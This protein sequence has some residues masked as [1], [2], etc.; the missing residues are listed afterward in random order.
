MIEVGLPTTPAQIDSVANDTIK[1]IEKKHGK[2]TI[3]KLGDRPKFIIPV[4]PTGVY[5]IDYEVLGVGGFP[6]GRIIEVMGPES[7]GKTTLALRVIAAAQAAGGKA[8]FIDVEHA[9]DP[10][11]AE[12]N[13]V[14][15]DELYVSQP[16][17]GEEALEVVNDLVVSG[18]WKVIVVDSVA[19]LVPKAELEGEMGDS[20]MGLQARLMS[21][22]MRKL[23]GV[24]AKTGTC[25]IFIN[26][27]RDKIGV[28][29]GSPEVTTGGKALKF[30]ASVRIDIRRIGQV[31]E[32]DNVVG[33][34]IKVKAV[35]NK[36]AAPFK[37][38]ECVLLY[39]SGFDTDGS[40]FDAAVEAKVIDK[41]GSW[42]SYKTEKIG[43]GRDNALAYLVSKNLMD[44]ILK[45]VRDGQSGTAGTSGEPL[46]SST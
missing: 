5:G 18:A 33:N 36:V 4:T 40:V 26:Q 8:A 28:L 20:H 15:T 22:A 31:K 41:S 19:A 2:G 29:F 23:T 30:Y 12:R 10:S 14:I 35:K 13:G 16:D 45:E 38:T 25:L 1:A 9:L 42:F 3:Y 46:K 43:Q 32:G 39:E 17:S 7:S 44:N 37:E 11:W 6:Q 21:Q 24:V 27:I 34:K